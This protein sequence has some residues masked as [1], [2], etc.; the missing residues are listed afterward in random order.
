MNQTLFWLLIIGLQLVCLVI[1]YLASK[2]QTT[3]SDYY[4]A[5]R[6]MPFFPLLMTFVAT[7]VGGSL[8]LG[9]AE[10]A[11]YKGWEIIFYPLG[12]ICGFFLLATFL[13]RRLAALPV[14]TVAQIFEYSYGSKNLKKL[15]SL[16]SI[17]TL[18]MITVAQVLASQ[19]FLAALHIDHPVWFLAFWTIVFIYT[20]W[21]GL[22]G[23]AGID[24]VQASFFIVVFA[25]S[26]FDVFATKSITQLD[27]SALSSAGSLD[28]HIWI[29]WFLMPCLFMLIEQ[30]M[31]Q[32]CFSAK[33]P[34]VVRR[35]ALGSALLI[36]LI[37]IV[38]ISFGLL[39]KAGGIEVPQGH[40]V[41]ITL[42][43]AMTSPT[44]T[45]AV[46]CAVMMAIISTAVSLIH[47]ISSNLTQDFQPTT[48]STP[49]QLMV[50]RLVTLAIGF[51]ALFV[52]T[53]FDNIVSL[54]IQSY[55][56]SVACLFVPVLMS[57]LKKQ[58]GPLPATL[59]IAFGA[60]SFL[61][62]RIIDA[63]IP[64]ELI[65]LSASAIGF[66]LGQTFQSK[67]RSPCS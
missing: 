54:V 41:L 34:A 59:A 12:A 7:Q 67:E 1:A 55:E 6:T 13:G 42:V 44:L 52:S 16:L 11:Y 46:A 37:C 23:I 22:A 10:D 28:P 31:A 47:S 19:K 43:Q 45:A 27:L 35:A 33:T 26:L 66:A 61:L 8:I 39:G 64:K 9:S 29:S 51:A 56:L 62:F 25:A 49:R 38:P 14:S 32:R 4:L 58:N 60:A 24:V 15:A 57:L 3:R 36:F 2:K 50:S 20:M 65:E 40:S 17:V 53:Y 63:P 21:G 30:D 48:T 5:G 18:F